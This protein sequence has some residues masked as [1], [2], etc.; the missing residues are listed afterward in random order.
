MEV[1]AAATLLVGI[2]SK[3]GIEATGKQLMKLI[4]PGRKWGPH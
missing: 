2:L 1:G 4:R 3:R